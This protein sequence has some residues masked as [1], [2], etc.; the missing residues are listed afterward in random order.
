ME[1]V[2]DSGDVVWASSE[3]VELFFEGESE[4]GSGYYV[5]I[6]GADSAVFL[7]ERSPQ[8]ERDIKQKLISHSN[9]FLINRTATFLKCYHNILE[10]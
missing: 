3:A 7:V 10:S 8:A 6:S 1:E 4:D 5:V 9:G 2:L